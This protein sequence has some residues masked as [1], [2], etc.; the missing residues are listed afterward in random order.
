MTQNT[1]RKWSVLEEKQLLKEHQDGVSLEDIAKAHQRS[2]GAIAIRLKKIAVQLHS[3]GE[4]FASIEKKTGVSQE[5]VEEQLKI[6]TRTQN[7]KMTS[8]SEL[9]KQKLKEIE[10]LLS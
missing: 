10:A 4:S 3:E 1:V 6:E 8:N 7:K 2:E 5:V 9:I